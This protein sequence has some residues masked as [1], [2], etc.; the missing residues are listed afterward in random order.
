MK[1]SVAH[2]QHDRKIDRSGRG[3]HRTDP[4]RS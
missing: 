4:M 3:N 2:G 1:P